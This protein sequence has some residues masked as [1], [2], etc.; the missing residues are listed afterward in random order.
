MGR[1]LLGDIRTVAGEAV[2]GRWAGI[3]IIREEIH[4]GWRFW[5]LG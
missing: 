2:C 4:Y 5:E 1:K 3:R